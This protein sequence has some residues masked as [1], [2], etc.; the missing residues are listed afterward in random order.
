MGNTSIKS[1]L[2]SYRPIM[3]DMQRVVAYGFISQHA[4][5]S[6][7]IHSPE[8]D[9]PSAII[10]AFMHTGMNDLF[11]GK[12]VF[13]ST[14]AEFLMSDL[15]LLLPEKQLVFKLPPK[16][17]YPDGL[18][19]RIK[20]LKA[21]GHDVALEDYQV[22]DVRKSLL[23]FV[24]YVLIDINNA[25]VAHIY[26]SASAGNTTCIATNVDSQKV[27]V[28]AQEIGFASFQGNYFAYSSEVVSNKPNEQ[29]KTAADSKLDVLDL[30]AKLNGDGSDK[31]VEDFFKAHPLL[32]IEML[33]LVN[34]ASTGHTREINSVHQALFLL[35]RA[36]LIRYFQVMLYSLD[37]RYASPNPLMA[38]AAWRGK[39]MELMVR[40]AEY[41]EGSNHQDQAYMVGMFSMMSALFNKDLAEILAR[42]NLSPEI[43]QSILKRTGVLGGLLRIAEALQFESLSVVEVLAVELNYPV[44]V[45]MCSQNDAFAWVQ[46][47]QAR[48]A[49]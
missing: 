36:P 14:S 48:L 39:F 42:F 49:S 46:N 34:A 17:H 18:A 6:R 45:L 2:F 24:N 3:D 16:A 13:V 41:T 27:L 43:S 20:E 29:R 22:D 23:P 38:A 8:N 30:L 33:R 7:T 47:F 25:D 28:R 26:N 1:E 15:P 21:F 32:T 9:A 10:N 31:I 37:N 11:C 19:E 44:D 4:G 35:G 12:L 40:H 5:D